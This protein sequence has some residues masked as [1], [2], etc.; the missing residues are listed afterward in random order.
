MGLFSKTHKGKLEIDGNTSFFD[1][2]YNIKPIFTCL[3]ASK[4]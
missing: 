1:Q 2:F 4:N 3:I